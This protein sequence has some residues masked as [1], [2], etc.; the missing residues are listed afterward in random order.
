[1]LRHVW[2]RTPCSASSEV[3]WVLPVSLNVWSQKI[4]K[5]GD[6]KKKRTKYSPRLCRWALCGAPQ[7]LAT[8]AT[9]LSQ[10]FSQPGRGAYRRIRGEGRGASWGLPE[11]ESQTSSGRGREASPPWWRYPEKSF[12]LSSDFS[13]PES[14]HQQDRSQAE[15]GWRPPPAQTVSWFF[16]F[17]ITCCGT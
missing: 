16:H 10:P 1:M 6:K 8:L 5:G 12:P 7:H 14:R 13:I 11:A 17:R 9:V 3:W 15:F 2:P 4:R